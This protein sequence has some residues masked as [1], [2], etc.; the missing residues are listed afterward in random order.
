MVSIHELACSLARSFSHCLWCNASSFSA[1]CT[2]LVLLE[3]VW[4][5]K[6]L[7]VNLW[8]L[9]LQAQERELEDLKDKQSWLQLYP[10]QQC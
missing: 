3:S 8:C 5:T 7:L 1:N 6:C 2:N 10:Q 9:M 4:L